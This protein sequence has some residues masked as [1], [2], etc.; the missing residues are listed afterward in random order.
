[1][2]IQEIKRDD[3]QQLPKA[4]VARSHEVVMEVKKHDRGSKRKIKESDAGADRIILAIKKCRRDLTK[5]RVYQFFLI[6]NRKN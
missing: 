3:Q 4:H 2:H 1:M 6:R 5:V